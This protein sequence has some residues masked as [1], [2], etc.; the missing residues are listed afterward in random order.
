MGLL[1]SIEEVQEKEKETRMLGITWPVDL[2]LFK[3]E[4]HT[5]PYL[6]MLSTMKEAY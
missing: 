5:L 2:W 4:N 3:N 1:G 6:N